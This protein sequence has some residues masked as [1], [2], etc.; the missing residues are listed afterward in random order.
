MS[1]F[2]KPAELFG[3]HYGFIVTG[4]AKTLPA[5]ATGHIFT[6]AGGRVLITSLTG[7]VTTATGATATTLSIGNTPTGGTAGTA[8]LAT[9]TSITSLSVGAN[10]SMP[11]LSS[12]GV[13]QALVVGAVGIAVPMDVGGL[14]IVPAGTIDVV[15]LTTDTGAITYSVTYVSYDAGATITAL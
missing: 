6:V 3:T 10:V 11:P 2:P 7:I 15:T 5:T 8:T 13:A 9:A 14:A 1:V 12:V 4:G